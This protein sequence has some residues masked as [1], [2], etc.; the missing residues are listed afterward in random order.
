MIATK[1]ILLAETEWKFDSVPTSELEACCLYEYSREYCRQSQTLKEL[2]ARWEKFEAWW[3][4][5]KGKKP[6]PPVPGRHKIGLLANEYAA[7]ILSARQ[8]FAVPI[9]FRTFPDLTWQDLRQQPRLGR[10]WPVKHRIC[11]VKDQQRRREYKGDRFHIETLA[12]LAPANIT[13]LPGW[14]YYHEFFHRHHSLSNTQHGFFAINWDWP[15]A[16][17]RRAFG[18]WLQEQANKRKD[19]PKINPRPSRGQWKDKLRWLGA[20]RVKNHYDYRDLVDATDLSLKDNKAPY[21]YY[22]ALRNA[23]KKA[24]HL[25]S[26]TFPSE[27]EAAQIASMQVEKLE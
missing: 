8:K 5:Q 23:V 6:R 15:S 18:Q 10:G 2:R 21:F 19:K 1:P 17:I 26:E 9:D 16:E 11:Q 22:P 3:G 27:N 25:I 12:Q 20:L 4:A 24:E 14:I 7:R 13:D